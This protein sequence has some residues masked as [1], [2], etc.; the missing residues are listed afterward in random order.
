MRLILS[1]FE[2]IFSYQKH[3]L[4]SIQLKINSE[5]NSDIKIQQ[6]GLLIDTH[7]LMWVRFIYCGR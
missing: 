7:P 2:K 6:E 4:Y 3:I 1:I 5:I